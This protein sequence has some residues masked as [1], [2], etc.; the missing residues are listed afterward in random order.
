[1]LKRHWLVAV[2]SLAVAGFSAGLVLAHPQITD[3]PQRT[4]PSPTRAPTTAPTAT[5]TPKPSDP[6]LQ[7]AVGQKF[8]TRMNGATPSRALLR[9][10]QSGEVGGVILF[11]QNARSPAQ[12]QQAVATLQAAAKRGGNP[13]LLIAADQEG[14]SV[15]RLPW[16]PPVAAAAVLTNPATALAQGEATARELSARRRQPRPRAGRSTPGRARRWARAASAP[17]RPPRAAPSPPGSH[18]AAS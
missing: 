18:A 9:R 12:L 8:I 7:R 2:L 15:R 3:S 11:A 16:A 14:G 1:M 6:T 4:S 10:V 5:A 13:K 17:R